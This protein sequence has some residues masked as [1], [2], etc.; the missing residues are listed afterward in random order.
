LLFNSLDFL[1]F[2]AIVYLTYRLLPF[3]AQN[4]LLLVA[5]YVFYG[6]W[7]VRFLFLIAFSTTVDF[8][9]GLMLGERR[10]PLKQRITASFFIVGAALLFVCVDWHALAAPGG[11]SS[12]PLAPLGG[13]AL[14][15]AIIL[16]VVGN[17]SHDWIAAMEPQHARRML[18]V[19]TVLVNLGFLATFKYFNFFIDSAEFA[20]RALGVA[21]EPFRLDVILPVGISFYTFQS[22]SYTLDMSRGLIAPARRFWDFAL[23]VAFFPRWSPA[24][25]SRRAICCRSC[26]NRVASGYRNRC[27]GWC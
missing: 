26:S 10:V 11:P 24:R 21:P 27:M 25:S 16:V 14:A 8:W 2:F 22:L 23:F 6:W 5:G 1:V 20:L 7:D 17:A 9:I 13:V 12:L 18:I 15:A 4:W 19:A 3:R